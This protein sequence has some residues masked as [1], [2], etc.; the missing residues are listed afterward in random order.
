[1]GKV[2]DVNRD[3]IHHEGREPTI[4]EMA[5]KSGLSMEDTH[6]ALKMSRQPLSLD[7][8]VGHQEENFLGDLLYD[9]RE[10]DPLAGMNMAM[11]KT[12][13]ADVLQGLDYREREILRLR[14]GLADG[15]TYTCRKSA[16]SSPLPG[17][18]CVRSSAKRSASSNTL[19]HRGN[20]PTS[21]ITSFRVEPRFVCRTTRQPM[22]QPSEPFDTDSTLNCRFAA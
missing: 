19:A 13:V 16:G 1:M 7:Q 22:C 11:L 21:W 6:R 20:L 10:E 15:Y 14:Y 9:H 3:M 18:E 12:R 8:P 17:S 4:E 5:Q 2:R